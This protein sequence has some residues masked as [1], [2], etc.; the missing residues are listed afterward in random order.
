M[1]KKQLETEPNLITSAGMEDS[2]EEFRKYFIGLKRKLK[3]APELE[4]VIWLHLKTIGMDSKEQ[5]NDGIKHFGYKIEV[6]EI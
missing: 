5:F 1:S 3:L 6:K 4:N 2:R